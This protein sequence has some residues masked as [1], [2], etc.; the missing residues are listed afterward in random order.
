[1]ADGAVKEP[2]RTGIGI[3]D[4]RFER[5]EVGG[6]RPDDETGA[7]EKRLWEVEGGS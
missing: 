6:T 4:E 2:V 3:L 1:V 5:A 7:L